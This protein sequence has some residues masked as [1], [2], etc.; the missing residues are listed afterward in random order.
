MCS[1]DEESIRDFPVIVVIVVVVVRNLQFLIYNKK[2]LSFL[3]FFLFG[4]NEILIK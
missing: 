4:K 3:L 1:Q 2:I